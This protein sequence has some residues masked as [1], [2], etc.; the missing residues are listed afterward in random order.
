MYVSDGWCERY[1]QLSTV[2]V[3]VPGEEELV[4]AG[5]RCGEAPSTSSQATISGRQGMT[6]SS[7]DYMYVGTCASSSTLAVEYL[8]EQ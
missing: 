7:G 3:S 1:L 2:I 6:L 8:K 4:E 5:H